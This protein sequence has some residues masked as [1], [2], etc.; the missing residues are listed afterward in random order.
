[1]ALMAGKDSSRSGKGRSGK[2]VNGGRQAFIDAAV[3]P[4][5]PPT[6][7]PGPAAARAAA[8][9]KPFASVPVIQSPVATARARGYAIGNRA[10][11]AARV[12]VPTA[13]VGGGLYALHR[14]RRNKQVQ[15]EVGKRADDVV[16]DY[17][18]AMD[19]YLRDAAVMRW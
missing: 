4:P 2:Y 12:V 1:V 16:L 7:P 3:T 19:G 8:R 10:G 9:P 5:A 18:E 13:V 6:P 15:E 14:S 11:R 17:M